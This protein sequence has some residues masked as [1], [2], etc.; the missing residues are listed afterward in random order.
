MRT[1]VRAFLRGEIAAGSWIPSR[2]GLGDWDQDFSRRVGERGWIGLTWPTEVG[3]GGR[4]QLERYVVSEEMLAYGAP[5]WFHLAADRQSGPMIL[6][7]G[8]ERLKREIIPGI[9]R[10]EISFCIGMSEPNSGSDVFAASTRATKVDGGWKV[11]G[12]KVWTSNAHRATYMIGLFRTSLATKEDRRH[13]LSNFVVN[14][15]APGITVRPIINMRG[16]HD[17]NEV[18][19]DDVFLSDD[20]LLGEVD[21]AWK[22]TTSELAYERSGPERF[23]ET[24]PVLKG[25]IKAAGTTPTERVAEGIGRE[26]AHLKTLRK[27]SFSVAGMLQAGKTPS[28][29]S[30]IVK[31]LGTNWEQ[32][33]P[34]KARRLIAPGETD[35][36]T[37][38]DALRI[39]TLLAPKMTIA[40]GTREVLRGIIA[41][42]LD[43]R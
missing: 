4:S 13:G 38:D 22:Q 15:K 36:A 11:S 20:S 19:F 8:S 10:G 30:A 5:N 1:E 23:L 37:Y 32:L 40:G 6:Q 3:G 33:L 16:R 21:E 14:M 34:D 28:V 25:L 35:C 18:S 29:E 39:S 42:G 31:D 17:F 2:G 9:I 26:V 41:R 7:Y 12:T 24:L 43:L 27:M